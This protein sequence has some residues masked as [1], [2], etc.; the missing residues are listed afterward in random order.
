MTTFRKFIDFQDFLTN[1]KIFTS[2]FLNEY[3][4]AK[5]LLNN[6]E[7]M[8]IITYNFTRHFSM[9]NVDVLEKDKNENYY[10]DVSVDK[11]GD[12]VDNIGV[13]SGENIKL[14]LSY[15]IGNNEYQQE[16]FNEFVI[17]S[18]KY[19]SLKIRITFLEKPLMDSEFKINLRYYLLQDNYRE[20][21]I[22]HQ[23]MTKNN[24]YYGGYCYKK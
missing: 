5:Y 3:D 13:K 1:K 10:Y 7:N 19:T 11:I 22:S 20:L 6:K 18:A 14:Q 2:N 23:V 9:F 16:Q 12:I 24:K 8:D 17:I 4:A 15:I 21:L